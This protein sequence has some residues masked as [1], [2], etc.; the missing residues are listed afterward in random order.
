MVAAP[1]L[2]QPPGSDDPARRAAALVRAA[3]IEMVPRDE[4][5]GDALRGLFAPGT[6]VFINHPAGATHHDIVA[7][8]AR[9]RRAGFV[10]V[11]NVA[12]R[13]LASYTQAADF[14]RRAVNEAEVDEVLLIG[15]DSAAPVGPFYD[16]IDLL[17]SGLIERQGVRRIAFAGYPDGHPLISEG[18]LAAVM[19]RKLALARS[20]G[21][22]VKIISQFGFEPGPILGWLAGLR[23]DG[24]ACQ[25]RLGIAGP[26]SIAALARV[27]VRCGIG[28]SLRALAGDHAAFARNLTEFTPDAL[29][30]ALV[31]GEEVSVPIAGLHIY[32]FGGVSRT[33]E[34]A[35]SHWR[36]NRDE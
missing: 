30:R 25:V 32:P 9:L 22:S 11:P 33:A 8:C 17:V 19:R 21:F 36:E 13:R 1:A 29:I 4:F 20:A 18:T 34:W 35:K 28:G 10:P 23:R 2:P 5:T 24:I 27:A 12:A 31:G 6:N 16:S 26:A 15:G 14:L 7:A 3:S